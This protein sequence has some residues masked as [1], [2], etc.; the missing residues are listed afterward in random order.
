VAMV[1]DRRAASSVNHHH[2]APVSELQGRL[3]SASRIFP[4]IA[5]VSRPKR[6]HTHHLVS[7]LRLMKIRCVRG[8][9]VERRQWGVLFERHG[10]VVLLDE[11]VTLFETFPNGIVF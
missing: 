7:A 4:N 2:R 1:V 11:T 8:R 5:L 9:P 3:N 6:T 10:A